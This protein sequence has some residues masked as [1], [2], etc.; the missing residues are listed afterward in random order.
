[1]ARLIALFFLQLIVSLFGAPAASKTF[2]CRTCYGSLARGKLPAQAAVSGS[3][4]DVV[5]AELNL[6]EWESLMVVQWIF[7][8][9]LFALPCCP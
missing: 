4:L 6:T 2:I 7:F 9:K 3:V 8:M 1:M 5:P